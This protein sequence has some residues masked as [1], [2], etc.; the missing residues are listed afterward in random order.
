MHKYDFEDLRYHDCPTR[1]S[2]RPVSQLFP[3]TP[4]RY[5]THLDRRLDDH[6]CQEEYDR[7]E[8]VEEKG[9]RFV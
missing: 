2:T 7:L 6:D 3:P 9:Q 8:R 1:Q 4:N 5:T